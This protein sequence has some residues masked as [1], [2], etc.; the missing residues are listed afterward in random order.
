MS[1]NIEVESK[2]ETVREV[3]NEVEVVKEVEGENKVEEEEA[4]LETY[5]RDFKHFRVGT[6]LKLKIFKIKI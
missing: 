2:L 6:N 4:A 5:S 1:P 3:D